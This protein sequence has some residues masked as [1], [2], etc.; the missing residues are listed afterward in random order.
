LPDSPPLD[1]DGEW[2][3]PMECHE[4][5]IL[6]NLIVSA[7]WLDHEPGRQAICLAMDLPFQGHRPLPGQIRAVTSS[8]RWPSQ[9]S[10]STK[11]FGAAPRPSPRLM[12]I[13]A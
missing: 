1:A 10:L 5:D 11:S 4:V 12:R 3:V 9:A 7:A 6:Q 2:W 13:P 8:R